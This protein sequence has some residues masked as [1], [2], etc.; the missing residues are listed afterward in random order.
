MRIPSNHILSRL[1]RYII[2]KF[3]GTYFFMMVLII[4]IAV[5]FDYNENVDRLT[6][7]HAT[8]EAI[9]G[10]YLT[11]VPYYANLF[12]SLFVFLA[13]IF[14]TSKLAGNSEIIAI[15]SAG[16]SI[17]RLLR[18]YMFSAALISGLA[19]YLNS[20]VIPSS[21]TSRLNFEYQFKNKKK[22]TVINAEGVQLQVDKGVIAYIEYFD[23]S[24]KQGSHFFLDK[25]ENKKIVS[26]LTATS[27]YYDTI[28][29]ER[30]HWQLRNVTLRDMRTKREVITHFDQLD[31]VIMMEPS[32]LMLT[33]NQQETMK[34]AELKHYIAKQKARGSGNVSTFEMEYYRRFSDS[35]A[36]FI[37]TIIGFSV[38]A[39]KRK[40]GSGIAIGIGIALS[41]VYILLQAISS[42]FS[43]N[44]GFS[45]A[46][47]A[48]MPNIIYL[49]IAIYMYF[50]A[51]R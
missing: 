42:S 19:F 3:L 14:F 47:A 35:C 46:L 6:R 40:G 2:V 10:Y 23:G 44:A 20:E 39:R 34:N 25:F 41:A 22:G 30:F 5:V 1:D 38:S 29:D 32:D 48:W 9:F 21:S 43:K 49:F 4:M 7:A 26:H 31:T 16:V 45:P 17:N 12:S 36:A 37:L 28:A 51:P 13:V 15:Q 50:K 24:T 8:N 11:F 33:R 18:P 27:L